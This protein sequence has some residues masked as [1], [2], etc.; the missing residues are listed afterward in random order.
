MAATTAAIVPLGAT[1]A[2]AAPAVDGYAPEVAAAAVAAFAEQGLSPA[3]AAQR[4]ASQPARIQLGERLASTLGARS[5]GVW[6]DQA[7]NTV[8]VNVLDSAAAAT[9]RAAGAE[10]RVVQRSQKELE[11]IRDTLAAAKVTDTAVGIDV[12]AN[13]VV[14]R[15]GK[16]AP[17]AGL[18]GMLDTAGTFG[19]AV[20]VE[21]VNGTFGKLIS[22]GFPIVNGGVCTLGFSTTFNTG[23]TAGHCTRAI[24][25]WLDG[26][27][28]RFYGP[29]IHFSFPGNDFGLIRND[30]GLPQPGNV[31]L[32]NGAFQDIVTAAWPVQ[33]MAI[34]KSG[35]TTFLTCGGVL[36]LGQVVCYPEGCV[37]DMAAT[38]VVAAPGDSGGPWFAGP[39]AFGLTSGGGGGIT[40]FQPVVE[41][42]AAY[43]IWVF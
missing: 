1:G 34:C 39:W 26:S 33:G 3:E 5:A 22:G 18:S 30:G 24:P 36:A 16:N 42:L 40:F 7:N 35:A 2:Q 9:V 21:K 38:N 23:I 10:T 14:L 28:G 41:V 6:L 29:S 8:V 27:T 25:A 17:A 19:G 4:L 13:Q 12:E 32:W 31:Y 43:G 11:S 20:R 37:G 15:V